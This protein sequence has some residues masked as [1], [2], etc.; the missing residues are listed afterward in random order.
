MLSG[1][2]WDYPKE[3]VIQFGFKITEYFILYIDK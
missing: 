1:R 2:L 3:G